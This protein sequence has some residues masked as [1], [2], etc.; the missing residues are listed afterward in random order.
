MAVINRVPRGLLGLLDAKTSGNTPGTFRED[1]QP[2]IDLTDYY[3]TDIPQAVIVET[4]NAVNTAGFHA[5][6]VVP[7][8]ELWLVYAVSSTVAAQQNNDVMFSNP[9]YD[10][11]LSSVALAPTSGPFNGLSSLA[12]EIAQ[13]GVTFNEPLRAL[14][15]NRF[16]TNLYRNVGLNVTVT[17][18]VLRKVIQI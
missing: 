1:L 4:D 6:V 18:A 13:N 2:V 7:D 16:L 15:G 3:E 9:V 5:G 10:D 14:P 12:G 11:N 17:T 8:G